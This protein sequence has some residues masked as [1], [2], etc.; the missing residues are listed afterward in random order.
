MV[1]PTRATKLALAPRRRPISAG[2][3]TSAGLCNLTQTIYCAHTHSSVAA[4]LG[5]FATGSGVPG[6]FL[7]AL[8]LGVNAFFGASP[9][10]SH[11]SHPPGGCCSGLDAGGLVIAGLAGG[12]RGLRASGAAT[13]GGATLLMCAPGGFVVGGGLSG[14]SLLAGARGRCCCAEEEAEAFGWLR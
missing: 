11:A 6:L 2:N 9:P 3:L 8:V 14:A 1:G 4:P 13:G 10:W 7:F 5:P 12:G